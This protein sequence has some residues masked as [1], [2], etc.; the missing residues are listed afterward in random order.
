MPLNSLHDELVGWRKLTKREYDRQVNR[1]LS[2]QNSDGLLKRNLVDVLQRGYN[3]ALEKLAQLEAEHGKVDSADRT[4]SVLQPLEGAAEELI[5]YAVQ[6][7]RTSCALSNFPT[8]HR[9]SAAYIAE[10]LQAVG[11]QWDEFKLKLGER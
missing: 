2:R 5:E 7:H 11:M 4:H 8:E 1:D 3:A 9:P 6:K 10:V